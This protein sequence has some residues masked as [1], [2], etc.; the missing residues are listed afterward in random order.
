VNQDAM[1]E[2]LYALICENT[3]VKAES[4]AEN[5]LLREDLNLDSF[6]FIS[7]LTAVENEFAVKIADADAN[8]LKTVGDVTQALWTRLA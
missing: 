6:D 2:K 3:S 5:K 1:R 7:V 8:Q 4:L